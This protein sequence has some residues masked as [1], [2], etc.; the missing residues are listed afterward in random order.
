MADLV[1][2]EGGVEQQKGISGGLLFGF[3]F[4]ASTSARIGFGSDAGG[5]DK[6]AGMIGAGFVDDDV[7]GRAAEDSLGEFLELA[8]EVFDIDGAALLEF[9]SEDAEDESASGIESAVEV[10]AGGE[11]FDA[12]G[13]D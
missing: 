3:F 7:F 8:F 6:F 5:D 9:V 11:R 1:L 10:D 4:A 12:G 2:V 13:E